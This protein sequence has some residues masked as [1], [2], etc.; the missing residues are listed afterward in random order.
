M[1]TSQYLYF[2]H[3]KTKMEFLS[4]ARENLKIHKIFLLNGRHYGMLNVNIPKCKCDSI[5]EHDV[6]P[7]Y[8]ILITG[9]CEKF[10]VTTNTRNTTHD[11]KQFAQNQSHKSNERRWYTVWYSWWFGEH[12]N[13]GC[14]HSYTI[15]WFRTLQHF[16]SIFF[17]GIA[18]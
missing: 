13:T 10:T 12:I 15:S 5:K 9:E 4:S 14:D 18:E 7:G 17:V 8:Y 1:P 11:A 6:S 16:G 3:S 2:P